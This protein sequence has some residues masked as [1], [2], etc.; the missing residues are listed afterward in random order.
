MGLSTLLKAAAMTV[1]FAVPASAS[2]IFLISDSNAVTSGADNEIFF[3]NVLNGQNVTNYSTTNIGSMGTTANITNGGSTVTS[4]ELAGADFMLWGYSRNSISSAELSTIASFY[5]AGGSLFLIGEGYVFTGL[6]SAIN[7]ILAA[8]GSSMSLSLDQADSVDL[9]S[10]S[11][12]TDVVGQTQYATGVNSWTTAYAAGINIGDGT[13]IISG[14]ADNGFRA[15]VGFEDAAMTPVP[16]PAG[17]P[18]IISALGAFGFL[19]ARR[20][21]S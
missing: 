16:I 11:T 18:L 13:A 9:G 12:M 17:A 10:F 1:A 6:N 2:S 19:R 5:Q 15:A 4:S 20:R 21:K 14:T 7:Q 3:Q 8:V